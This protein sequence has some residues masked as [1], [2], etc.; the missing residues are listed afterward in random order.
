MGS[1][2]IKYI[3]K[4]GETKQL[5]SSTA[6]NLRHLACMLKEPY[7]ES[8]GVYQLLSVIQSINAYIWGFILGKNGHRFSVNRLNSFKD[9]AFN[10]K[11]FYTYYLLIK[12][13][14][15]HFF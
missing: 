7:L 8:L 4:I 2:K 10:Q 6:E 9:V 1:Q 14:Y 11:R 3:N 15:S 13:R 5:C 12:V